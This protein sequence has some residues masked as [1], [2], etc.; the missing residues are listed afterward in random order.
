MTAG[1]AFFDT[2]VL[3]Y[4][5]DSSDTRKR[6]AARR[7]LFDYLS[8]GDAR[9]STQALAEFF[10]VVTTRGEVT[11]LPPAA[12]WLIEHLPGDAV[13]APSRETLKAAVGRASTGGVSIWDS[14][15]I[16]AAREAKAAILFTEDKRVLRAIDE[17]PCGLTGIDP[18]AEA[19][20][21]ESGLPV[22]QE[23]S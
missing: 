10:S 5:F 20:Q 21:T 17:Y 7:L 1:T 12:A 2:S 4:A 18:F 6:D 14:L 15:I 9:T 19:Q 16:E 3:V 11:L 22:E 13:V 8:S 23:V